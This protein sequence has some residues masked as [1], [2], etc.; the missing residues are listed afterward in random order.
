MKTYRDFESPEQLRLYYGIVTETKTPELDKGK[1]EEESGADEL[2]EVKNKSTKKDEYKVIY[3][4]LKQKPSNIFENIIIFTNNKDPKK[5]KTLDNIYEAV[6]NLKKDKDNVIPNVYV[7][8]AEELTFT[9]DDE[10]TLTISDGEVKLEFAKEDNTNTMVFSRL[11]VQGEDNCE[12]V[13]S[14]LQDRGFL[15]LNP[16]RY[17][18]LACNKYDTAVLLDKGEIPQPRYCAM[19]KS[20]LYDEKMFNESLKKIYETWEE[21]SEESKKFEFVVKIL[22]GHGGTGVSLVSGKQ[23][24]AILQTIFAIDPEVQLMIQRKE[25][26][27]GGDIRVHVLT[28]RDKQI[29]LGAMKRIKIKSDFRSNVSLGAT[30]EPVKLTPEQEQ[31]ALKTAKLSHLPWCAVDIMPLVKGSNKELG[32]NVVLEINASPGTQGITEVIGVNFINLLLNE[33]DNPANFL[34]QDKTVGYV[35]TVEIDFGQGPI[36]MLAKLDTGN[37]TKASCVEVGDI[38]ESN[39]HVE[40]TLDGKKY[41]LKRVGTSNA[42][43]GDTKHERPIVEVKSVKMG[44]RRVINAPMALVENR[45]KTTNVLLNRDIMTRFGAIVSPSQTHILTQEMEKIKII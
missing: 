2:G 14:L 33:L 9:H 25:E 21:G 12:H 45:N 5:N 24:K 32:D 3:A 29:I 4:D 39:E 40:F 43:L 44:T 11:G 27:D 26:A 18:E 10:N 31:I 8:V 13:V 41:K 28:L 16:V 20:I 7:F 30:A 19:S 36:K 37:G 38:V 1:S 23:I 22:D 15:V 42:I 34:L 6:K 35:E 17:S